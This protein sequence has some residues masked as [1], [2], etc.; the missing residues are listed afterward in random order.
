MSKTTKY[1]IGKVLAAIICAA[2]AVL[3]EDDNKL[4]CIILATS[5]G[6]IIGDIITTLLSK[7][8]KPQS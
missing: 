7:I 1:T 3:L 6:W 2:L 8:L 5:A 4:A